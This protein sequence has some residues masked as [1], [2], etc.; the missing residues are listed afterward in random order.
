MSRHEKWFYGD[1]P[2]DVV[3][4]YSYLGINFTT[5]LSFVNSSSLLIAKAKKTV[6]EILFSLK[7]LSNFDINL[8]TSSRN[9]HK[10]LDCDTLLLRQKMAAPFIV[11]NNTH[12]MM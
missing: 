4:S 11:V 9:T 3:N 12:I 8:F 5:R 7:S 10:L 1:T 2:L 6:I